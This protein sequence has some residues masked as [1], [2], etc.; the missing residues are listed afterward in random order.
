M[1]K[2][3]GLSADDKRAVIL[4]LYHEYKEPFNLKEIEVKASKAGVVLQTVKDMNQSLVDDFLVYSDKIGS[5]NFFW[6]FPSKCS[7]DKQNEK[8][9]LLGAIEQVEHRLEGATK[10]IKDSRSERCA[11]DRGEKVITCSHKYS[12]AYV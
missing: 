4:K 11:S 2:K 10:T 3:R 6:S 7:V 12:I 5:A 1:S 9:R 8:E